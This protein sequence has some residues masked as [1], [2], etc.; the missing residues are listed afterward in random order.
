MFGVWGIYTN[1]HYNYECLKD[2]TL[3]LQCSGSVFNI[4]SFTSKKTNLDAV[5]EQNQFCLATTIFLIFV[6]QKF[7]FIQQK[8]EKKCDD[9][10]ISPSDY[11]VM[12]ENISNPEGIGMKNL[13]ET[14]ENTWTNF[15]REVLKEKKKPAFW[16]QS[17][18]HLKKIVQT[19]FEIKKVIEA[20][21]LGDF[22]KLERKRMHLYKE[23]RL[24]L[25]E[26]KQALIKHK[27]SSETMENISRKY[28][29]HATTKTDIPE[30]VEDVKADFEKELNLFFKKKNKR[31]LRA[32]AQMKFLELEWNAL[33]AKI[34]NL[35]I[36]KHCP[37][38]FITLNYQERMIFFFNLIC[39]FFRCRNF[40]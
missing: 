36:D 14:I 17:E 31:T 34:E 15:C 11:T 6:L 25:G 35:V 10:L 33:R 13:H 29:D 2:Q 1:I 21:Q 20:Y 26:I 32:F 37:F 19:K 23:K 12:V 39:N 4:I 28:F 24:K 30:N 40:K 7:R 18:A 27:V 5:V 8:T 9:N 22:I 38:S 16:L 3:L